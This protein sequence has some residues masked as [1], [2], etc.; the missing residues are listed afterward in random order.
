[1]ATLD[2][3]LDRLGVEAPWSGV[4]GAPFFV[5]GDRGGIRFPIDGQ[6]GGLEESVASLLEGSDAVS[7]SAFFLDQ[8]RLP[9]HVPPWAG[10]HI[11]DV[12]SDNALAVALSGGAHADHKTPEC[13]A[14]H[15]VTLVP[16][17]GEF[18]V[19]R[20]QHLGCFDISPLAE[21][22]FL[23]EL[24]FVDVAAVQDVEPPCF[25][26]PEAEFLLLV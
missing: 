24:G 26:C 9:G 13:F 5:V 18:A 15:R 12:L 8:I 17:L 20:E 16:R 1:M 2:T 7:S 21:V 4:Q 22:I 23:A 10:R 6:L 25:G 14:L 3:Q 11:D 19:R